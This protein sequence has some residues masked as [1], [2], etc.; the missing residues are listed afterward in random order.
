M[1]PVENDHKRIGRLVADKDFER[2]TKDIVGFLATTHASATN[3]GL[4]LGGLS[5]LRRHQ[6]GKGMPPFPSGSPRD[7]WDPAR[8]RVLRECV[9]GA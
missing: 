7:V 8:F 5:P 3:T 6:D 2:H 4:Q 9:V 1:K